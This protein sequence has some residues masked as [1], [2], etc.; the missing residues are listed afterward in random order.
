MGVEDED[1]GRST[2]LV[3]VWKGVAEGRGDWSSDFSLTIISTPRGRV[4][5]KKI[6]KNRISM[7]KSS[8]AK[9]KKVHVT[10]QLETRS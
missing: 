5:F 7:A 1:G 6:V 4:P 2:A 9:Q 8:D 3:V 10:L